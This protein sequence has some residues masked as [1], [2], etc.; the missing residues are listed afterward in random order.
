MMPRILITDL[1]HESIVGMLQEQGFSVDYHPD[2][3]RSDILRLLPEYT[4][5]I[6]RSKTAVDPELISAGNRLKFVARSGAG[7]DLIDLE[8]AASRGVAILHAAEGNRDAVAEHATGMLLA[9]LHHLMKGDREV[10]RRIWD[11]E[12]NRGM[13]LMHRC[14]GIVGHGNMGAAFA[15]RL[16]G[17]GCRVLAYDKYKTGFGT[18]DA[19]E[20]SLERLFDQADV[21]SLHVP[22]TDETRGFYN[23]A[24]FG[25]FRHNL[26]VI[27]TARGEILPLEDLL[28]EMKSGKVLAAGL[29]VLEKENFTRLSARED[30][31][32]AEMMQLENVLFTPHVAGW[33]AESY[34]KINQALA[35]KI[36]ALGLV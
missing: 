32:L 31:V 7:L 4:G 10:R 12:G 22:L 11:R 9:L 26:I 33:T 21:L 6:V 1:M 28:R 20:S 14:V 34:V 29:D 16:S 5:L 27:N 36:A 23:S 19:E 35:D 3:N 15:R 2:A 18:E 8:F 25:Q 13:E 17:F 24:F 30:A